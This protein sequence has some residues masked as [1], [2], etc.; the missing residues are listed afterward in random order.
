MP[1]YIKEETT[2]NIPDITSD[3]LD[4]LREL[5]VNSVYQLAVQSPSG[6]ALEIND[7]YFDVESA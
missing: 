5:N 6:L 3:T 7:A 4:K 2:Q 1:N